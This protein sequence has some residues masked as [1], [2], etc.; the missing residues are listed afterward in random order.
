MVSELGRSRTHAVLHCLTLRSLPCTH[1]LPSALSRAPKYTR[2]REITRD[3]TRLQDVGAYLLR[4]LGSVRPAELEQALL[5]LPFDAVRRLLV[6]LLPLLAEAPPVEL[7]A[8]DLP[9]RPSLP[10]ARRHP[11]RPP[12]PPP[13][14]TSLD[15]PH[16]AARPPRPRQARTILYLLRVHHKPLVA[17][18]AL[19]D[20]LGPIH[21]ALSARVSAE[22]ARLG[23][24]VAALGFLRSAIERGSEGGGLFGEALSARAAAAPP[25]AD[26]ERAPAQDG[27]AGEEDGRQA[28]A[29]AKGQRGRVRMSADVSC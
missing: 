7:M 24:N 16:P 27:G 26:G 6:R 5:L 12:P 3:Y 28:P 10:A 23:Y 15:P 17:S 4:A 2:L 13:A 22:R 19:L 1:A 9:P 21:A 20:L 8:R 11:P 18:R 25:S 29:K 14:R